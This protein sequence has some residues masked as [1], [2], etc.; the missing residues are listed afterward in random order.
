VDT[1]TEAGLRS[2]LTRRVE[3]LTGETWREVAEKVARLGLW[4]FEDYSA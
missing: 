3:N 4:E 1:F 2:F